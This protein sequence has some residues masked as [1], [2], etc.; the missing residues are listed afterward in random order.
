[1]TDI[2]YTL[3]KLTTTLR[4]GII[5]E[6]H[7][8]DQ[9]FGPAGEGYLFQTTQYDPITGVE[10][11]T[12]WEHTNG[13]S[14]Y[15]SVLAGVASTQTWTDTGTRYWSTKKAHYRADGSVHSDEVHW[16][17]GTSKV[18]TY[19]LSGN[20]SRIR[21]VDAGNVGDWVERDTY[22]RSDGLVS[23]SRTVSDDLLEVVFDYHYNTTDPTRFQYL[24]TRIDHGDVE[25]WTRL[26]THGD[27]G[28][29]HILQTKTWWDNGVFEQH[30]FDSGVLVGWLRSD[31]DDQFAWTSEHKTYD[32][33]GTITSAFKSFDNGARVSNTY[34]S[35]VLVHV[36]R[37]DVG[38]TLD[39]DRWVDAFD[40]SGQ[41]TSSYI[42]YDNGREVSRDFQDGA[43]RS[44]EWRGADGDRWDFKGNYY[45][46]DGTL[47]HVRR[48]R[49]DGVEVEWDY[50]GGQLNY[51]SSSDAADVF[52]WKYQ[53]TIYNSDGSIRH[54]ERM[55][56]NGLLYYTEFENDVRT[57]LVVEDGGDVKDWYSR[58]W[59]YDTDG[60]V[61][62]FVEIPDPIL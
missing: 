12:A 28:S 44:I 17:S 54:K 57:L 3:D 61:L 47:D 4:N 41:R 13:T 62:S 30:D 50:S 45:A 42:V 15:W 27:G 22:Y 21:M 38:T 60:S 31:I 24:E 39:W 37:W 46:N 49:N 52:D 51:K 34:E 33:S 9:Y 8:V 6:R 5:V 36:N 19:D 26:E 43:L 32:T 53:N 59:E 11:G 16:D 20:I 40:L 18:T 23:W 25:R 29:G 56:D 35:G 58:V 2:V 55:M 48:V 1:M 10:L 14:G 7:L